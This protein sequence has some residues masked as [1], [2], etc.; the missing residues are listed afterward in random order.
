MLN[1]KFFL[2]FARGINL[3]LILMFTYSMTSILEDRLNI[4]CQAGRRYMLSHRSVLLNNLHKKHRFGVPSSH[5][6]PQGSHRICIAGGSGFLVCLAIIRLFPC[7]ALVLHSEYIA[8]Y[9]PSSSRI[10][11]LKINLIRSSSSIW[12]SSR[13]AFNSVNLT[14]SSFARAKSVVISFP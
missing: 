9:L 3:E 6:R 7:I 1:R 13:F 4:L 8:F 11:I 12:L 2:S 10:R 14:L 5:F